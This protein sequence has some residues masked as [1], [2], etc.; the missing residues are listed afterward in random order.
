MLTINNIYVAA[1]A[2]TLHYLALY[3]YWH[4]VFLNALPAS[5]EG[6]RSVVATSILL[7][8]VHAV[9]VTLLCVVL[10]LKKYELKFSTKLSGE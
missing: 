3:M 9:Q 1:R 6:E 7:Q 4:C 8:H 10:T 5:F 2:L